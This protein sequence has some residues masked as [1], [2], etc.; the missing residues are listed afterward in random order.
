MVVAVQVMPL[1]GE[2]RTWTAPLPCVMAY[3]IARD[4]AEGDTSWKSEEEQAQGYANGSDSQ[5]D[6]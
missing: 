5:S 2:R 4:N 3:K 1:L 6:K